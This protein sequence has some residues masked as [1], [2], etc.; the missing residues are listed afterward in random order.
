MSDSY[1]RL[2]SKP[3]AKKEQKSARMQTDAPVSV[4]SIAESVAQLRKKNQQLDRMLAKMG[5]KADDNDFR[6]Q[7]AK[8]RKAAKK[9]C[10]DIMTAIKGGGDKQALG[11]VTR[12]FEAELGKFA[13]VSQN[14]E[15]KERSTLRL[16]S[17]AGSEA[18]SPP[19]AGMA[20]SNSGNP[21]SF[22]QED[23]EIN[24]VEYDVE[25]IK[26]R[27]EGIKQIER[28]VVEVSE[29]FKDLHGL[30]NEQ[31]EPLD[32]IADNIGKTKTQTE[33]AHNELLQAEALQRKARKRQCCV[34]IL[35]I[36]VVV[37]VAL[38]IWGTTKK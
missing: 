34:V 23:M 4:A 32:V 33:Q 19:V 8:E 17:N 18:R 9:L 2:P 21:D 26:R 38:I 10:K 20:K 30:V 31:Q 11:D 24:F 1:S 36:V 13:T 5:T 27:E 22:Q 3:N 29:M 14:I 15:Q 37:T 12:E 6:Q 16:M 25:E 7:M 35:L 28:D